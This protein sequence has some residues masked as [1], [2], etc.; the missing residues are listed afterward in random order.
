MADD[1][2]YFHYAVYAA[3]QRIPRGRVT[4]YGHI[5]KLIH[6]PRMPRQVGI[7]LKQ[8]PDEPSPELELLQQFNGTTVPWWRVIA[9]LGTISPRGVSTGD[10]LLGQERQAARLREESVEVGSAFTVSL[11]DYGWFPAPL[12]DEE[13][14]SE[15]EEGV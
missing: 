1:P 3:V 5:A 12:D 8:L 9:A 6:C 11:A 15:P 2:R 13:L 10:G 7:S 14:E 4:L